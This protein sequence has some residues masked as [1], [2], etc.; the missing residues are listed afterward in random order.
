MTEEEEVIGGTLCDFQ[1]DKTE[2]RMPACSGD[3]FFN[4]LTKRAENGT[5]V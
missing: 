4:G 5:R 2:V 3:Y 1:L